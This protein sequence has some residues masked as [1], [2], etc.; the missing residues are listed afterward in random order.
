[1]TDEM[2]GRQDALRNTVVVVALGVT[3][4]IG[5]GTLYYAFAILT[6]SIA[7]EFATGEATLYAIFSVGLLAGG[8]AAPK[9]GHWMDRFGAPRLMAL[10]SAV[11]ACLVGC[12]ALAPNL[13]VFGA[14]VVAIEVVSVAVLYDAAFA[15]LAQLRKANARRAITHLTLIAGFAS[16][17]FWPLTGWF[18]ATVGWRQTYL[19]FAA[20]HLLAAFP[21][22]LWITRL[23]PIAEDAISG[24]SQ[25]QQVWRPLTGEEAR[26]AFW[27]VA[28]SFALSGVLISA[29]TI[30][31]VP[32]LQS[33]ELGSAAYL[34]A[35]LMGPAQVL[36]RLTDALF[37]RSLHPVSV[38]LVA[39]MAMPLAILT[40][41]MPLNPLA[42]SIP[43][44]IL[45]GVNGGLSSIVRGAVPLA[46]FGA[47]GYGALLGRLAAI[48]TVLSAGAPFL[49]AVT[50]EVFGTRTA[51]FV[52]LAIS[53]A[54][55]GPLIL[56]QARLRKSAAPIT[57]TLQ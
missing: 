17:L 22:H 4:V 28:I 41:L 19:I 1:M 57:S 40:L 44:A 3:Q 50:T 23:S 13:W 52:A 9:L 46:L 25:G 8:L 29:L 38:A 16:T 43:F 33:L 26:F 37:W 51:L 30:H 39:A 35:M 15:T 12:L 20:M 18:E 56:L 10:G 14:L 7:R 47:A 2:N 27:A 34:V 11:A 36:I 24:A 5:Y 31:L 48:R 54:A 6:P 42:I 53:L 49:F 45:L 55:L 21:L 32:T